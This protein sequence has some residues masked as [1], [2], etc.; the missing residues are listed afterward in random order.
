MDEKFEDELCQ[1][2][3]RTTEW[4]YIATSNGIMRYFPGRNWPSTCLDDG[5]INWMRNTDTELLRTW[6]ATDEKGVQDCING[7]PDIHDARDSS[8]YVQVSFVEIVRKI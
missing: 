8:W 6:T 3:S 1:D 5:G 7:S 2:K 4:S